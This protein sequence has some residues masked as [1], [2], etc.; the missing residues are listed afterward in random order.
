MIGI[1]TLIEFSKIK[2]NTDFAKKYGFDFVELNLNLPY[3]QNELKCGVNLDNSLTYTLHFLDEAEFLYEEVSI[4][5]ANY[6]AK[7]LKPNHG[8]IKQVNIHLNLG[9]VQTVSG[10]KFYL[11]DLY[12]DNYLTNLI[13]NLRI[14]E[15]VTNK[16]GAKLVIENIHFLPHILKS[17][18]DLKN[19][20]FKFTYDVGHD[21]KEGYPLNEFFCHNLASYQ[22][23]HLHDVLDN[24]DHLALGDGNVDINKFYQLMK[25]KYLLI[26]VKSTVDLIKSLDY[27][28]KNIETND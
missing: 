10:Q 7:F 6:L 1:P 22:E 14:I 27:I 9:P 28:K 21:S 25:Y 12:Y 13:N 8:Q 11:N 15:K 2:D 20:G 18:A 23:M 19:N 3:V 26:E 5:Y 4:G 24:K 16:Y 17:F